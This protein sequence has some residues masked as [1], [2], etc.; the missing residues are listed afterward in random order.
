[1]KVLYND[2][3]VGLSAVLRACRLHAELW[4]HCVLLCLCHWADET[5]AGFYMLCN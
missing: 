3:E 1:M 5:A 2:K 4:Q